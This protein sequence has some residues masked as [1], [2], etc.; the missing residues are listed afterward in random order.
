MPSIV[1]TKGHRAFVDV[2]IAC[3][4]R[5]KL[6]QKQLA[7]KC[8]RPQSWIAQIESGARGVW[9]GE[10]PLIAKGLGMPLMKLLKLYVAFYEA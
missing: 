6:T 1:R 8:D 9:I 2:L 7:E 4:K 5:A 3:R 10:V